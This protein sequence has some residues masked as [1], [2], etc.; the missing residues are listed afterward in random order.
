MATNVRFTLLLI[1]LSALLF[2]AAGSVRAAEN[3]D[4]GQ[5]ATTAT[6]TATATAPADA[7]EDAD[8]EE[9]AVPEELVRSAR[10]S[11]VIVRVWYKKDTSE[12][13]AAQLEQQRIRH[14]YTNYV[15]KKRPEEKSGVVMDD[16]G[17]I[18]VVDDGI[19]DR[20]IDK[21]TIQT[22][23]GKIY[24]AGR[25]K[26]LTDA[27]AVMLKASP[28]AADKLTPLEFTEPDEKVIDVPLLWG[29]LRRIDEDWRLFFAT[30]H[31]YMEYTPDGK[32]NYFYGYR[33]RR[34]YFSSGGNGLPAIVANDDGDILGCATAGFVDARQ[35]ECL[36]KG[37]DLL[38]AS[39]VGWDELEESKEK[40]RRQLVEATHEIVI[41]LRRGD[42]NR[43]YGGDEAAGREMSL[44]GVAISPTQVL[45][46]ENL[47]RKMASQIDKIYIKYSPQ[48]RSRVEFVC[49]YEDFGAFVV[50]LTE[51][52]L[53][54]HVKIAHNDPEEMKPFFV[55]GARKRF[56]DKYVDLV[57]NRLSGK[58]RGYEGKFYWEPVR[59]IEG[60]SLLVNFDGELT[61]M[62]V[63]Q[64]IE[65]EE[66]RQL[67]RG[68]RY[69]YDDS[70]QRVFTISEVRKALAEPLAHADAKIEV[71]PPQMAKRRAWL[72]V[73]YMA[74]SSDLA[75]QFEAEK[76]TK[77]GQ[78]GFVVNAVYPGSPAEKL[79]I[80]IGDILL[81]IHA[82]G[83]P[84]P[85]EL[86]PKLA[87]RDRYS[88]GGFFWV[89]MGESESGPLEKAW[90]DRE[91]FLTKMVD[92]IGVGEK[93]G[94]TFYK[95][96]GEGPDKSVTKDYKIELAPADFDSAP[97]WRNRKIGLT[98]KDLTYEIR[99]ALNLEESHPGVVVAKTE[100]GSPAQIARIYTNEIITRLDD[101]PL[102]SAKHMRD[103]VASA[104]K[105]GR[106][107]VRLTIL[108]L[109]KTR[110]ADLDI[111]K[112]DPADDEGLQEE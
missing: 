40:I 76:P 82:P 20:F 67:Q 24:P 43:M 91:N 62:Y 83:R 42:N 66:E 3:S 59:E 85:I 11:F 100:P 96:T 53:P 77:D 10:K 37:P 65:H 84:Y 103:L 97:K 106:E 112:Y 110:F 78:L 44:Y 56:G 31:P 33:S 28:E 94:I 90:K 108:R 87:E 8:E 61:G 7:D 16:K 34:S 36:W 60:G 2:T 30:R 50:K 45:V 26:L 49:A 1:M 58:S 25:V 64:K 69:Y 89:R 57:T 74:M 81:R 73:E 6:A 104:H 93:I 70:G 41:R 98:V 38:K 15:D 29:I 19:E 13:L 5:E 63:K 95:R 79:G 47:N 22:P 107:K 72:G 68:D 18:L 80:D 32:E 55:A 86:S 12:S 54:A 9:P 21:I 4:D 46:P 71:Q 101:M 51:G 17:H 35:R 105:A 88:S 39:A 102:K 48:R 111:S 92:A 109:G 14:I 52:K 99:Y 75:E 27:P 23:D